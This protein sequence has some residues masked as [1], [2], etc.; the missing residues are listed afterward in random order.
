MLLGPTDS[1][2]GVAIEFARR[3]YDIPQVAAKSVRRG[4]Y[5]LLFGWKIEMKIGLKFRLA[6][7]YQLLRFSF[8]LNS[9]SMPLPPTAGLVPFDS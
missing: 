4:G 8:S 5:Y 3:G 7:I 1:P 6:F 2:V 9:T